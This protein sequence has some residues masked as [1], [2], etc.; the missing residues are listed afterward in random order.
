MRRRSASRTSAAPAKIISVALNRRTAISG[1][2]PHWGIKTVIDLTEDGRKNPEQHLV[3]LSGM[4]FFR[5]PLTTS[6]DHRQCGESVFEIVNDPANW[7]VFVHCQ[8]GCHRTG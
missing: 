5:I 7:P 4:K 3:Q 6:E 1:T 8:G 2:S